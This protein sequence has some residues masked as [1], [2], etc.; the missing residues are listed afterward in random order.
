MKIERILIFFV[1]LQFS[2][3]GFAQKDFTHD[4]ETAYKSEQY[5]AAIDL[6]KKAYAKEKD[7][8]TK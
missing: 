6:Y 7:R 2:I 3:V 5:Y 1:F 4:A 8:E